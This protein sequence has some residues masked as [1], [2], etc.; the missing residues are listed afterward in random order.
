M[1][2]ECELSGRFHGKLGAV[3]SYWEMLQGEAECK[4]NSE[5][6]IPSKYSRCCEK[7]CGQSKRCPV[8]ICLSSG[9][10]VVCTGSDLA[11][12]PPQVS[13]EGSPCTVTCYVQFLTVQPSN[14]TLLSS[15]GPLRGGINANAKAK[16]PWHLGINPLNQALADG[17]RDQTNK[18]KHATC[19]FPKG[20]S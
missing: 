8:H 18:T 16:S 6:D 10:R 19:H 3:T 11:Q 5:G 14:H 7:T 12:I 4:T 2:A 17:L 15:K 1:E 20:C 13:P 9:G